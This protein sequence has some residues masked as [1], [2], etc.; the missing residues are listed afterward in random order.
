MLEDRP[1]NVRRKWNADSSEYGVFI[2][3]NMRHIAKMQ[4]DVM[5]PKAHGYM[6]CSSLQ[7]TIW[8]KAQASR[9]T[10]ERT[11]IASDHE[12]SESEI[13]EVETVEMQPLFEMDTTAQHY[14]RAVGNYKQKSAAKR[15]AHTSAMKTA[16]HFWRSGATWG[17]RFGHSDYGTHRTISTNHP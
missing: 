4:G 7:Y 13:E 10:L 6:R 3:K 8:Y 14:S 1:Y 5:K 16:M 2:P 17:E 12:A 11:I 15:A 9:I